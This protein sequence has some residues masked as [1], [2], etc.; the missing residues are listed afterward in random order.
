MVGGSDLSVVEF[1][2]VKPRF[3]QVL[4]S[5]KGKYA[6]HYFDD[7]DDAVSLYTLNDVLFAARSRHENA[8]R[9]YFLDEGELKKFSVLSGKSDGEEQ[10]ELPSVGQ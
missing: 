8:E 9:W 10:E 3:I 6:L 4:A 7:G 5:S 1:P 2:A